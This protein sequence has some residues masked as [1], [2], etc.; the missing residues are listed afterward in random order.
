[1]VVLALALWVPTETAAASAADLSRVVFTVS[2]AALALSL[3][4]APISYVSDLAMELSAS[5][6]HVSELAMEV[7]T[8]VLHLS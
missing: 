6:L 8:A 2:A 1:M 7:S 3:S 5:A 4:A